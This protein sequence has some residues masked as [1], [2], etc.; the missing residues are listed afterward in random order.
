MELMIYMANGLYVASYF[1]KDILHLRILSVVAALCLVAYFYFREE[2]ML[3][4]VCW[5][6]FFVGVN[7]FQV[8]RI[9]LGRRHAQVVTL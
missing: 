6:L 3:T 7:T 4:V 8:A 9:F 2:P 1:M 5:N